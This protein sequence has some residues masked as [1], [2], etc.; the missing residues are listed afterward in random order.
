MAKSEFEVVVVGGGAAGI[1]AARKLHDAGV[2]CLLLEAR[3][4]LG[5]RAWTVNEPTGAPIDL[6]CGWLH[7][8]DRNRWR[9]IA[10]AQG[11]TIDKTPPPWMRPSITINFSL[12]D[13]KVFIES[14]RRFWGRM[15]EF[16][17]AGPDAPA[18][19]LLEPK[20]RW[21]GLIGAIGTFLSGTELSRLSARDF[22]RYEDTGVNW[23]VVEGY[24][25]MVVEHAAN[26]SVKLGC[27][28]R[29]I[30]HSG[31]RLRIETDDGT[32]AADAAIVTIPSGL[33]ADEAIGFTPA[34]PE[35]IAAASGLPLGLAD[36]LF[37]SL[38]D[39][40]EFEKD[41]RL[42]GRTDRTDTGSYHFRPFGRPQIEAYY[43]GAL[44]AELEASGAFAFVDFALGELTA[45]LG[46]DFAKRVKPIGAHRWK[47]DEFARGSYSYALPGK[48]DCRAVLAAPVESRLLFAGEAC[49]REDYSTAHGAY[50]TGVAAAD[51]AIVALRHRPEL[52]VAPSH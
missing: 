30:D 10:E 36:K 22:S 8:A 37:F 26:V 14:L 23:R 4:R 43:G 31:T 12:S 48:A 35:K 40:E 39:A 20:N 51:Q 21:N 28:V 46:R 16:P 47:A 27:P 41:T 15:G 11:R 7:S 33:I 34:L 49:S 29:T 45:L 6:G 3:S 32:I 25:A 44:A 19:S 18:A 38:S 2:D 24:G 42:F 17:E 50:L 5:G 52:A 1:A 13:Q 9:E